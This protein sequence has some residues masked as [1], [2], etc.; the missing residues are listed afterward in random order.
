MLLVAQSLNQV[1]GGRLAGVEPYPTEDVH[2]HQ[3]LVDIPTD[4]LE[5]LQKLNSCRAV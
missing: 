1:L 5:A 4:T 2:Q 3:R